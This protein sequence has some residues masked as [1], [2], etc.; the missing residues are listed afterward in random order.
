MNRQE[1]LYQIETMLVENLPS[2]GRRQALGLAVLVLGL[3]SEGWIH[4]SRIAEGA[5][6]A[7]G[8]NT[9]RQRAKRWVSN[10]QANMDRVKEEW[11]R[12]VWAG[13]GNRRAVLLVDE[14][15]L[16]ERL[17][18]MMVSLAYAG[19]AIPLWWRCYYGNN[20]NEYPQQGQVLL[21]Y[22]LLAHVLNSLPPQ[23]RPL[24]QMDRGLAH[25]SAMLRAL[26]ALNVDFL[27]R[28]KSNARFTSDK[29]TSQLLKHWI[30]PG[31]TKILHGTLF[32]QDHAV[33]GHMALCWEDGQAEPWCL[34]T[35]SRAL[36]PHRYAI[37]WW[38]EEAFRDLKSGGWHWHRSRIACPYRMDRLL[39]CM[40]VAYAWSI[41]LGTFVWSLPPRQRNLVATRDELPRLSLFRL[42]WRFLK[43]VFCRQASLPTFSLSFPSPA[44]FSSA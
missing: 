31:Q 3:V 36:V 13:Y 27:V 4:L 20:A 5:S 16:G 14:T 6:E 40:A 43:R 10:R 23:V 44:L 39:L 25:S 22:G 1:G 17:G 7:G 38:Q 8:Y 41:S 9:V 34:F 42:G 11:V 28:V 15:K 12:W 35:N 30:A 26:F 19:R 29:G 21:I 32:T 37:R 24:V 33:R 2:L 18:V